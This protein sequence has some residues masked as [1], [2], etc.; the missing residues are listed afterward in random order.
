MP[1]KPS[2]ATVRMAKP[3]SSDIL[4]IT[5]VITLG[6]MWRNRMRPGPAPM[7]RAAVTNI[8]SFLAITSPRTSR[9]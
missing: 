5:G 7:A 3:M 8:S 6:R 2:E 9:A 1:M 4:T